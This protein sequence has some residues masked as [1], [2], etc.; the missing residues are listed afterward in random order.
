MTLQPLTAAPALCSTRDPRGLGGLLALVG[1]AETP[2]PLTEVR[3][4]ASLVG[5]VCRTV[6]EQRF[7]NPFTTRMEAI[8]L[9]PV[10]EEGAI[11]E[12]EL[13]CGEIVV[14]AECRERADAERAFATAREAGHRAALV[15]RE[16]DDIHTLRV[17]NLPPGEGVT[18]RIVIVEHLDAQDGALRWRFPTTIAPRY[19]PGSPLGHEGPG[20]LPDTTAAPDASHLQPPIRLDGGTKLDLEVSIAGVPTRVASSLHAVSMALGDGLR[21]APAGNT[22]CD[23][24]FVLAVSF[25]KQDDLGAHAWTDGRTTLVTVEPPLSVGTALPRDAVFVVDISGSMGGEKLQAAKAALTSALH[26]LSLGDRFQLIAFDD[27]LETFAG[28]YTGYTDATLQRADRW[29]AALRAR[30]GTEMLPAIQAALAGDTPMGRLRTVLFITDG[31]AHNEAELAAAVANRRKTARF[32]T[33]GI[34]TAVNGALLTRLARMGG[35]TCELVTPQDDIEAVVARLEAR[36]GSPLVDAVEIQGGELARPE[37]L[38]IFHGRPVSALLHGA[39]A[40]VRVTGHAATGDFAFDVTP[41]RTE[42]PLEALWARARVA[43]LEDRLVLRPFEEEAILPEIRRIALAAGIASRCTAFVAVE[44]TRT[45]TGARVG[46]LQPHE[47]PAGWREEFRG[48]GPMVQA[49][50]APGGPRILPTRAKARDVDAMMDTA[51]MAAPPP[52]PAKASRRSLGLDLRQ[53]VDDQACESPPILSLDMILASDQGAD[54]SY[55]RDVARTAAALIL[56][57]L[58]GHTR[59]AGLRQ[60]T[61]RKAVAW[62]EARRQE[63]L[64]ALALAA[65]EAAEQGRSPDGDYRVLQG[66][67]REGGLLMA[68]LQTHA[69]ARGPITKG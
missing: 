17:T 43:Y 63:P 65:V 66:A 15:T 59:V 12:V 29:V 25:A 21:V 56:L 11:I 60:R 52:A 64:A 7:E 61:V 3:V 4:R 67:G 35:G 34:D 24:D 50:M 32:F 6:V 51:R 16:R 41:A 42:V 28:D 36:F 54:G 30:G 39:P 18:V 10:P 9:F 40:S 2:F 62:L 22:T 19:L 55:G 53:E 27:R 23:R 57:V 20:V 14:R 45:T 5:S 37:P 46:V 47:L 1:R 49:S 31:Q 68:W 69:D 13:Q 26:G 58:L 38:T 48:A 44:T 33:L 8:H